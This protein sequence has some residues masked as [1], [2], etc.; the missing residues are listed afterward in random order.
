MDRHRRGSNLYA[1]SI[2]LAANGATGMSDTAGG[3]GS[4]PGRSV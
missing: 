1:G 4:R 2:R 3:L